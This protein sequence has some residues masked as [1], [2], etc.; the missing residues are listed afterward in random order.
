MRMMVMVYIVMRL[1]GSRVTAA[2]RRRWRHATGSS[3]GVCLVSQL[4]ADWLSTS[5]LSV[6]ISTRQYIPL[7]VHAF[8]G[9]LCL[10]CSSKPNKANT[11]EEKKIA[12]QSVEEEKTSVL[13]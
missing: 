5:I 2:R 6:S 10:L 11:F 12:Q 1:G 13:N 7:F 9:T 8:N 4:T 3:L